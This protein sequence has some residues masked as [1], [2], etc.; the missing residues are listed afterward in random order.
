VKGQAW[1][2]LAGTHI[3]DTG[4]R[5]LLEVVVCDGKTFIKKWTR[6]EITVGK[7]EVSGNA[8]LLT[9]E[10]IFDET[11]RRIFSETD[12]PLYTEVLHVTSNGLE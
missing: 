10:K 3:G 11:G 5:L 9:W 7:V 6:G 8:V 4:S 2:L 12:P 1:S